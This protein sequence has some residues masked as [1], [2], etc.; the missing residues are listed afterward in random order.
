MPPDD[1]KLIGGFLL[2][3]PA[4]VMQVER[5][6]TAAA[7]AFRRRLGSE[8]DDVRQDI[9]MELTRL[10]SE[11]RFRGESAAVSYVWRITNH[12]CLKRIR[13]ASRW[14][15]D[16]TELLNRAKDERKTAADHL[17]E[18][19]RLESIRRIVLQMPPECIELWRRI[20]EG[21]SYQVI[22]AALGLAEGTLRVRVLRCR[23]KAAAARET[24]RD[25]QSM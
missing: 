12:A 6:V 16:V 25:S 9:L 8:W 3:E 2:G 14:A 19:D 10:F 20:L 17:L 13:Q 11:G 15:S 7:K 23:Q 21:Q 24:E 1:R 4:A 18:Q 22:S 5:W